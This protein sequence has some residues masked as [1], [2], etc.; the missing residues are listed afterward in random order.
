MDKTKRSAGRGVAGAPGSGSSG[1]KLNPPVNTKPQTKQVSWRET[2]KVHPAADIF[3]MMSDDELQKLG[4]DIK[5]SGLK[6]PII[7]QNTDNNGDEILLDGRNRLE[8]MERAGIRSEYM[9]STI[10]WATP[11]PI[12]SA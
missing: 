9:T 12:S 3:P 4:E 8:A 6:H 1:S 5:A 11:L 10:A 2:Y 7:F